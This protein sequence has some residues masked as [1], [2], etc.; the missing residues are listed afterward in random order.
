MY[1]INLFLIFRKADSIDIKN[2][3]TLL[4]VTIIGGIVG[5]LTLIFLIVKFL[6]YLD[7]GSSD[8]NKDT[9]QT[10]RKLSG[11]K[12][13]PVLHIDPFAQPISTP[14]HP[15]SNNSGASQPH[16]P[17]QSSADFTAIKNV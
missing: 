12:V 3:D 14:R 5:G 7:N 11:N 16:Y 13:K 10:S 1:I 8:K 17:P 2:V 15:G 4:L 9:S 6:D